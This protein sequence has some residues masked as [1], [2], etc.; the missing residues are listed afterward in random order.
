MT[1]LVETLTPVYAEDKSCEQCEFR[2]TFPC[3]RMY[4]KH[5]WDGL[6]NIYNL[7]IEVHK[8]TSLINLHSIELEHHRAGKYHLLVASPYHCSHYTKQCKCDGFR[9]ENFAEIPAR[10]MPFCIHM[11]DLDIPKTYLSGEYLFLIT[12][13]EA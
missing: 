6:F 11:F 4:K 1:T 5:A 13:K 8:E 10:K 9:C 7:V 2:H 3:N 12:D